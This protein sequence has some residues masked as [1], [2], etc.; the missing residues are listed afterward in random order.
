EY[1]DY[2]KSLEE[3]ENDLNKYHLKTEGLKERFQ[4]V[5]T[6]SES[7]QRVKDW[8]KDGIDIISSDEGLGSFDFTEEWCSSRRFFIT[9]D[10]EDDISCY[11]SDDIAN[12][13]YGEGFEE[14]GI[15]KTLDLKNYKD[16]K[17]PDSDFPIRFVTFFNDG[18]NLLDIGEEK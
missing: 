17:I 3:Y 7:E 15:Q 16:Y 2:R 12:G 4:S 10:N 14:M 13:I 18:L 11:L 9:W 1:T 6:K 8:L 5:I